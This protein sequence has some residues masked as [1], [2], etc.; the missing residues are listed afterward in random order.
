M[1]IR[2][3]QVG[4]SV[5][6]NLRTIL[7]EESGVV[8]AV[9]FD[10][11]TT[12][13]L[14]EILA[15]SEQPPNVRLLVREDM[16]KWLRDDFVLASTA[17]ELLAAEMLELRAAAGRLDGELVV[18]E[19]TV[20]SL[21]TPDDEQSAALVTDDEEFV[22]AAREHWSDRWEDGEQFDLRTPAYS[23][24]VD[25]LGEEFNSEMESDFR[26]ALESV[27]T[28][29][30]ED[31]L[32]EVGLSLLVAAKHE[33][34]LYD[35]SHWG[36]DV[37]VA[38]KATFSRTKTQF[39]EQ[40]LLETEKVPIDVGRPRLRLVLGEERLREADVEE[41]AS[42]ARELLAAAPA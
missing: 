42:V 35:I 13:A 4:T 31:E 14:I 39:E 24:V 41:L 37:G 40:G 23:R 22:A 27:E 34:L 10:E 2:S 9:G 30:G 5:G 17:A 11:D 29:D 20:V 32:D 26:T 15:N 6:E 33:Q 7:A 8:S 18:T 19:E 36:E 21:L 25:S 28:M 3:A 12:R 16:L 1:T 38:S